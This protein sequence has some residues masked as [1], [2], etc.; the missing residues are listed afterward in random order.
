[1][2]EDNYINQY[3]ILHKQKPKYGASSEKLLKF[4]GEIIKNYGSKV[5]LDYGCGKSNLTSMLEEDYN[6]KSY[7]YDPAIEEYSI[8]PKCK[9]DFII[10]TDVLQHVPMYDIDRVLNKIKDISSNVLFYIKCAKNSTIL[11]NGV[12]ANCTVLTAKRWEKILKK[13]FKNVVQI[14]IQDKTSVCF[15]TKEGL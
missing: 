4:V 12:Y 1:M 5:I 11:P 8:L 6:V 9:I 13:Y 10:C 2:V 14:K 7:K 15:T 3:S